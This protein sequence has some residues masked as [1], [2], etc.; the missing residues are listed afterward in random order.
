MG[1]NVS[2]HRTP[3]KQV[4]PITIA[5]VRLGIGGLILVSFLR[6]STTHRSI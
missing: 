1:N 3:V 6:Y 5:F 2:L 4:D